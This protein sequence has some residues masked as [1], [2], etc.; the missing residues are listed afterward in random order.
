MVHESTQKVPIQ[1]Q[2]VAPLV[3]ED[4]TVIAPIVQPLVEPT[5]EA[6]IEVLPPPILLL[7]VQVL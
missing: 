6:S 7:I 1:I 3:V 5:L 2:I 4:T